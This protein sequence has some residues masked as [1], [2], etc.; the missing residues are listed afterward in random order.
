M[1]EEILIN[2]TPRETRVALVE[3]GVLQEVFIERAAKRGLVGNIY[4]GKV[5]RVLPGMQAAFVDVGLERAAFLHASDVVP[6]GV[7][8]GSGD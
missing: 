3:N 5:C 4:R 2:V 8:P 1:S 7:D 6:R